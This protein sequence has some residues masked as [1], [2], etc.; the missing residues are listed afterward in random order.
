MNQTH[1]TSCSFIIIFWFAVARFAV[2][3]TLLILVK[4]SAVFEVIMQKLQFGWG[5][6]S[7]AALQDYWKTV[8]A[9]KAETLF[10]QALFCCGEAWQFG[11]ETTL[12]GAPCAST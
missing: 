5:Y 3:V 4:K 12:S 9:S 11:L 2:H 8:G 7:F 1:Y 6:S 10:V